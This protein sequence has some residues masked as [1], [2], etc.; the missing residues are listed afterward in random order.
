VARNAPSLRGRIRLVSRGY[1]CARRRRIRPLVVR[2]DHVAGGIE[3]IKRDKEI[4]VRLSEHMPLDSVPKASGHGA[5]RK[6]NRGASTRAPCQAHSPFDVLRVHQQCD[7][8]RC[9]PPS[10]RC[11]KQYPSHGIAAV[12]P[13]MVTIAKWGN[14][15]AGAFG[16]ADR[17]L[18]A[19]FRFLQNSAE[20]RKCGTVMLADDDSV[21]RRPVVRGAAKDFETRPVA[22]AHPAGGNAATP[23]I[24]H[25]P[26]VQ[27]NRGIAPQ[28][29]A[30]SFRDAK[31]QPFP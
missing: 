15:A 27:S 30:G 9:Q 4:I 23:N 1:V 28:P 12:S 18:A 22:A 10:A 14:L 19:T 13:S 8:C 3:S 21:A 24:N 31:P 17:F 29:D 25:R 2:E 16:F 5:N 20:T 7:T 11:I 26:S 6:I